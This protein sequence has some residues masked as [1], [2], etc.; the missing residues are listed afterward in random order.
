[1]STTSSKKVI[2][3]QLNNKLSFVQ[4]Y[5]FFFY[6]GFFYW[7]AGLLKLHK[8]GE[9]NNYQLVNSF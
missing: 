1:M 9:T 6:W 3:K 7:S 5:F 8:Y 2:Q 4:D